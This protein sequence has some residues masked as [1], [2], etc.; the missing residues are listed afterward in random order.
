MRAKIKIISISVLISALSSVNSGAPSAFAYINETE[1]S[2][3]PLTAY[4]PLYFL[5]GSNHTKLEFSFKSKIVETIPIFIAYTQ[6]SFWDIFKN[7]A[8]FFDTTYAPDLFYRHFLSSTHY[9]DLGGSHE[10]NGKDGMASRSWNRIFVRYS[11]ISPLK[12]SKITWDLQ[13]WVPIA[14]QDQSKTLPTYRGI[15][16]LNLAWYQFLGPGF[17]QD[18]LILRFYPGG[19]FYLNPFLGGQEL[20]LRVKSAELKFLPLFL[21]QVFH[22]YGENLIEANESITV[23]RIGIGF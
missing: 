18:D 10:S 22:G 2:V 12:D 21:I 15:F 9:L 8:P 19:A 13:A 17:D 16:E 4:R 3:V 11:K 6:T 23:A 14:S 7:S 20:T 5:V 1:A